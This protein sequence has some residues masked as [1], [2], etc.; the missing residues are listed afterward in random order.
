M[1]QNSVICHGPPQVLLLVNWSRLG[2]GTSTMWWYIYLVEHTCNDTISSPSMFQRFPAK[3]LYHIGHTFW[4]PGWV[5]VCGK[6]W[7]L[8]LCFFEVSEPVDVGRGPI[9]LRH[10]PV[11]VIPVLC[12]WLLM[13][14]GQILR[15][16][17]K[18]P[19]DQVAL[20]AFELIWPSYDRSLL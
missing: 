10:T 7:C 13:F 19:T 12:I 14:W 9:Q 15:F 2:T 17:L 20:A 1:W 3:L 16:L 5:I 8:A 6:P 18:N 4:I 11:L